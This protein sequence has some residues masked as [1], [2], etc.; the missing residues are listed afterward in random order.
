MI[1]SLLALY[2]VSLGLWLLV[3]PLGP[4]VALAAWCAYHVGHYRGFKEG[5]WYEILERQAAALDEPA[6]RAP[7]AEHVRAQ[8]EVAKW[9]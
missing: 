2:A 4:L 5:L 8:R 9:Q 6:D 1:P 7:G 3:G